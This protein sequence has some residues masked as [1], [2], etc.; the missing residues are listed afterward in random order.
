MDRRQVQVQVQ[1]QVQDRRQG[2]AQVRTQDQDQDQ[3]LDRILLMQKETREKEVEDA[4]SCIA[5]ILG[6][7]WPPM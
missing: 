3:V 5:G 2:Q 6:V 1:A 4:L 7:R